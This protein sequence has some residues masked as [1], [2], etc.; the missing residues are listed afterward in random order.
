ME[1]LDKHPHWHCRCR[2]LYSFTRWCP[3]TDDYM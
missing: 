2:L 3:C 1:G